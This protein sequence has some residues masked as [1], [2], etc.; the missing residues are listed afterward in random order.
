MTAGRGCGLG[1]ML[2]PW[3]GQDQPSSTNLSFPPFLRGQASEPAARDW[4]RQMC[5]REDKDEGKV[6]VE[7]KKSK[8]EKERRGGRKRKGRGRQVEEGEG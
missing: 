3:S 7:R 6:M 1:D 8:G 4:R 5:Q 2:L